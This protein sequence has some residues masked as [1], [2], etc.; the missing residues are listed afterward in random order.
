MIKLIRQALLAAHEINC[1]PY[2]PM[3]W[4]LDNFALHQTTRRIFGELQRLFN[5]DPIAVI[6]CVQDLGLLF[7]LQVFQ[8][9]DNIVTVQITN[10][11]GQDLW[12]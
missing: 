5:R 10:R 6:K 8:K 12:F 4:R 11:L 3:F 9:V 7:F 1:L 2:G